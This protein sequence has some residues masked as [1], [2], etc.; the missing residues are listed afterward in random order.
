MNLY[1]I[2]GYNPFLIDIGK[3]TYVI[4]RFFFFNEEGILFKHNN[5]WFGNNNHL[6]VMTFPTPIKRKRKENFT[7]KNAFIIPKGKDSYTKENRADLYIHI[8]IMKF[9]VESIKEISGATTYTYNKYISGFYD[10]AVI[11]RETCIEEVDYVKAAEIEKLKNRII[12]LD[13]EKEE[14][15]KT[16]R[17]KFGIY[18]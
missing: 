11:D 10:I 17:N 8:H 9:S 3:S 2:P 16:L 7:E 1:T 15:S 4:N 14:I 18:I 13:K 12:E 6:K 5:G